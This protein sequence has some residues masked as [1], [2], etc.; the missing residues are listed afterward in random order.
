VIALEDIKRIAL[1]REVWQEI[2]AHCTRKLEGNNLPGES[3]EPKAF[4]LIAGIRLDETLNVTRILPAKKNVRREDPY[5]TYVDDMVTRY[6]VPLAQPPSERGWVID[7]AEL[8]ELYD[9][10]E[11]EE[12]TVLGAYH[13]HHFPRKDDPKRDTPTLLDRALAKNS[14]FFS[15]IVSMVDPSHP[16]IRAFFEGSSEKEVPVHIGD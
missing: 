6:A 1:P 10:C 3:R 9:Q 5:K 7:P 12:L 14:G 11:R 8:K 4:G 15:F 16:R 13:M 2:E